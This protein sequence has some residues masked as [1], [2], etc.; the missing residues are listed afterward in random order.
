MN[1]L[2]FPSF[3]RFGNLA[4]FTTT[5]AGGVSSGEYR[6]MNLGY[7]VGDM[8]EN[9]DRNRQRLCGLLNLD[10]GHLFVP[11]Q[12]HGAEILLLEQDF[13]NAG[14]RQAVMLEGKDALVTSQEGI[15][16]AV[17]TADCVPVLLYAEDKKVIAAIH[18][19][20]RGTCNHIVQAAVQEMIRH[21][22]CD[23]EKI[24]ALIG[25]SIGP[26]VFEVGADVYDSFRDNGFDMDAISFFNP[27]SN[28][29][30]IN[31][32]ETNRLELMKIDVPGQ[33]IEVAGICTY[34]SDNLFSARRSGIRSGRMLTGIVRTG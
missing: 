22:G 25:P 12:V 2:Q 20:W 29:H 10:P 34:R 3:S 7:H 5:S 30:H 23:P 26:D 33:Q 32:W 31:L 28:K 16:I 27:V 1:I 13:L 11:R 18:A 17:Q 8:D 14:D 21:Y 9:V 6:S 19:G 15:C 24:H 4:H